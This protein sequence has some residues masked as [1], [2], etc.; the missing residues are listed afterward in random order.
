MNKRAPLNLKDLEKHLTPDQIATDPAL[1]NLYGRDWLKQWEGKA[2][3][4]V[5]PK[6]TEDVVSIVSWA[7]KNKIKLIPSG[8]RT[9]LS[10]GAAALNEELVVS[11]DR[12]NQLSD[13]N[14]VE[15]TVT[16]EPG[17]VTRTV[18]EFALERG[19][20]FPR[21][22]CRRGIQSNRREH[23]HQCRRGSC[24]PLRVHEGHGSGSGSGHGGGKGV[25]SGAG[26]GKKRNRIQPDAPVYRQ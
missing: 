4:V 5:F 9:G 11:F 25:K 18:Q 2:G 16:V 13:F 23:C 1:L 26:T 7:G 19:C 3:A 24:P 14:P 21:F 12:M 20:F 6:S 10:G 8:G 22:L 15:R 17:V